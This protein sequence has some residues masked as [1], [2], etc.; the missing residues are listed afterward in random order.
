MVAA[1]L[2]LQSLLTLPTSLQRGLRTSVS[3]P[4]I[5]MVFR[6]SDLPARPTVLESFSGSSLRLVVSPLLMSRSRISSHGR[7][8]TWSSFSSSVTSQSLMGSALLRIWLPISSRLRVS[9]R[10]ADI[11][12]RSPPLRLSTSS[13]L[14]VTLFAVLWM[15][16]VS[17]LSASSMVVS[18]PTRLVNL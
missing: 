9:F 15:L 16:S 2:R 14:M 3:T 12:D 7:N 4:L 11:Q 6:M 17:T 5:A 8:G 18:L 10:A 1:R 13:K